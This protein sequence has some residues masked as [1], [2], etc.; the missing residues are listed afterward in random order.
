MKTNHSVTRYGPQNQLP[1]QWVNRLFIIPIKTHAAV[2]W[3]KRNILFA[4]ECVAETEI[5]TQM[6]F[7]QSFITLFLFFSK[8]KGREEKKRTT[9][10]A[11]VEEVSV[12]I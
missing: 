5:S 4:L 7:C 1:A 9:K 3:K 11:E 12:T 8:R 10:G 6:K 2:P